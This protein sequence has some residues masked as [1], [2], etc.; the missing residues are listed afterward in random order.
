MAMSLHRL[1]RS[2]QRRLEDW[3]LATWTTIEKDHTIQRVAAEM[4]TKALGVLVTRGNIIGAAKAI[5]K[6]WPSVAVV[7]NN[8][9]L[10]DRFNEDRKAVIVGKAVI[11]IADALKSI[12]PPNMPRLEEL[13]R[14]IPVVSFE[15]IQQT[16]IKA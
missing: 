16:T 1:T 12:L 14:A 13:R 5:G 2:D 7:S 4:A 8:A 11:E 3:L 6:Q 9:H 10:L 15:L